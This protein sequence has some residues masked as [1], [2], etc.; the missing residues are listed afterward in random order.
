MLLMSEERISSAILSLLLVVTVLEYWCSDIDLNTPCRV[1]YQYHVFPT[2]HSSHH[3]TV[4]SA[5]YFFSLIF[6]S[7]SSLRLGCEGGACEDSPD[8]AFQ[9]R[10]DQ[11][12]EQRANKVEKEVC[13]LGPRAAH[14]WQGSGQREVGRAD[15]AEGS[16]R[17]AEDGSDNR[18]GG[19]CGHERSELTKPFYVDVR[20][21][22]NA[23]LYAGETWDG[24]HE[25]AYDRCH[26]CLGA[27]EDGN[28]SSSSGY[29]TGR[30]EFQK[31]LDLCIRLSI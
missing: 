1:A 28:A 3:R 29:S 12:T 30:Y 16:S 14:R 7:G 10:S 11:Y 23:G 24:I 21:S 25:L 15:R 19:G 26:A 9:P 2:L 31:I 17:V 27:D 8:S 6:K 13:L 5:R 22:M 4:P 20:G 18:L